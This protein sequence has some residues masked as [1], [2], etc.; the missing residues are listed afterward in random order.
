M[1]LTKLNSASVIDR[2]PVGS[3]IQTL[4]QEITALKVIGASIT[5][6]GFTLNITPTFS[7]SIIRS[8]FFLNGVNAPNATSTWLFYIFKAGSFLA[9]LDDVAGYDPQGNTQQSCNLIYHDAPNSTSQI[10]YSLSG[11]RQSG[12]GNVNFNNYV[13][14][15]NR[16][17]SCFILEEIK[18]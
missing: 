11:N 16:T 13:T 4:H 15:N 17:R 7:N 3:V 14:A 10:T 8:S 12:S 9:Y 6:T 5:A 1:A 18:Q 2:L